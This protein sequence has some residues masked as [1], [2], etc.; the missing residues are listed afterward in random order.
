MKKTMKK[1]KLMSMLLAIAMIISCLPMAVL[2]SGTTLVETDLVNIDFDSLEEKWWKNADIGTSDYAGGMEGVMVDNGGAYKYIQAETGRGNVLKIDHDANSNTSAQKVR[3]GFKNSDGYGAYTYTDANYLIVEYDVKVDAPTSTK[4]DLKA[5]N[6]FG[7]IGEH[8]G[9]MDSGSFIIRDGSTTPSEIY[10]ETMYDSTTNKGWKHIK[11]VYWVNSYGHSATFTVTDLATGASHVQTRHASKSNQTTRDN[12]LFTTIQ[13]GAYYLDNVHVYTVPVGT[14]SFKDSDLADT[15]N[16]AT[17]DKE[18]KLNFNAYIGDYSTLKVKAGDTDV[19]SSA[20]TTEVDKNTITLRFKNNLQPETTYTVDLSNV[21]DAINTTNNRTTL[22]TPFTFTTGEESGE[23]EPDIPD[24]PVE[25]EDPM[26]FQ[27]EFNG[28][29]DDTEWGWTN[30]EGKYN[31]YA[32]PGTI[33]NGLLNIPQNANQVKKWSA[34]LGENIQSGGG[35]KGE[36]HQVSGKSNIVLKTSFRANELQNGGEIMY[37]MGRHTAGTADGNI[38]KVYSTN[39]NLSYQGTD[40]VTNSGYTLNTDR[41]YDLTIKLDFVQQKATINIDDRQGSE[42]TFA[43]KFYG[44]PNRTYETISRLIAGATYTTGNYDFDYI[45]LFDEDLVQPVSATYGEQIDLNDARGIENGT[46]ITIKFP[47]TITQSDVNNITINNGASLEKSLSADGKTVTATVT[48]MDYRLAYT[49]TVPTAGASLETDFKF[50]SAD[51]P[52]YLYRLE[53]DGVDDY[54]HF[55]RMSPDSTFPYQFSG[56]GVADGKLTMNNSNF[57]YNAFAIDMG[58]EPINVKGK[59]N[60]NIST[61]FTWTD[62]ELNPN[63]I[64]SVGSLVNIKVKADGEVRYFHLGSG[65]EGK[66]IPNYDGTDTY[67][68]EKDKEYILNVKLNYV[69]DTYSATL[70]PTNGDHPASIPEVPFS[71]EDQTNTIHR[72]V[73]F[74]NYAYAKNQVVEIDYFRVEDSD[75]G[76]ANIVYGNDY[77]LENSVIVPVSGNEF[78]LTLPKAPSTTDGITLKKGTNTVLSTVSVAGNVVSVIPSVDLEYN[79]EYVLTIPQTI[80]EAETQS[81]KFTTIW[82]NNADF[83]KPQV[84]GD[85]DDIKVLFIGGSITAQSKNSNN[86]GWA[87]YVEN[88]IKEWYQNASFVNTAVGGTGSDYGWIRME[89]AIIEHNPDMVFIEF[90]VNDAGSVNAAKHME[91]IVRELN[92]L[93]KRPVI[94]FVYVTDLGFTNNYSVTQHEMIA[95]AYDIPV[96]DARGYMMSLYNTDD[97]FKTAWDNKEYLGDGVHTAQKGGEAYGTYINEL[98]THHSEDYFK[99]PKQNSL[100]E[101]VADAY[102][103]HYNTTTVDKNITAVNGT[104]ELDFIGSEIVIENKRSENGGIFKVEIDGAVVKENV[105]ALLQSGSADVGLFKFADLEA[106]K[107]TLKIT[108]TAN[109]EGKQTPDVNITKLYIKQTPAVVVT[110]V[111]FDASALTVGTEIKAN[112]TYKGYDAIP[113][114]MYVALYDTNGRMTGMTF[115]EITSDSTGEPKI[116]EKGITPKKDDAL[117]KAFVWDSSMKPLTSAVSVPQAQ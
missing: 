4:G 11:Y 113:L 72:I 41:F 22:T 29:D 75:Y 62:G 67:K 76:K 101:V 6:S 39:G 109:S 77:P 53:F 116:I 103:F 97:A 64:M 105:D 102:D 96:L 26:I 112:A 30:H 15:S 7:V 94:N 23:G 89:K 80:T 106:K 98:L 8:Q 40:N 91:S 27:A 18:I 57:P 24:E 79:T 38:I 48:G 111:V 32:Y 56:S 71:V 55:W 44:V 17:D 68:I 60:I 9:L 92:K 35:V 1:T 83:A 114:V 59:S 50:I 73:G 107:H 81:I 21:Y 36:G 115:S 14:F 49:I 52:K 66:T 63:S 100:V 51:H 5:G 99:L 34:F 10:R 33:A 13:G 86:L 88:Q 54:S 84:F 46:A 42:G 70:T 37:V 117:V 20:Y 45:R 19:D 58:E 25:A 104:I 69:D 74:V 43:T 65:E 61:K 87:Y 90:A 12:M 110:S 47:G 95:D 2:A 31:G 85:R 3:F 82:D 78:K 93:A 16:V 28:T 108:V